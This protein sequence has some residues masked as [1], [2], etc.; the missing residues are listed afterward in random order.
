MMICVQLLNGMPLNIDDH[1]VRGFCVHH[2]RSFVRDD[3]SQLAA[4]LFFKQDAQSGPVAEERIEPD[5][6]AVSDMI[7]NCRL[8]QFGRTQSEL[9]FNLL[10]HL[11]I[12]CGSCHDAIQTSAPAL[13]EIANPVIV[14][15]S[16]TTQVETFFRNSHRQ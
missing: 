1:C 2:S 6:R 4:V 10:P 5:Q 7:V 16:K 12:H 8:E 14:P 11:V 9:L 15:N 13:H 3:F